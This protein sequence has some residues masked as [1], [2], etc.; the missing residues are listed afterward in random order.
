MVYRK[1]A[2][3]RPLTVVL[4]LILPALTLPAL[5]VSFNGRNSAVWDTQA[6]AA[7]C[8]YTNESEGSAAAQTL[9][10]RSLFPWLKEVEY[11]EVQSGPNRAYWENPFL[12]KNWNDAFLQLQNGVWEVHIGGNV[13]RSPDR[14]ALWGTSLANKPVRIW[15]E[16][17]MPQLKQQILAALYLR[18][19]PSEWKIVPDIQMIST[20]PA[21]QLPHVVLLSAEKYN[22]VSSLLTA[23]RPA[24]PRFPRLYRTDN[25]D[26]PFTVAADVRHFESALMALSSRELT[27]VEI[28]KWLERIKSTVKDGWLTVS[29]SPAALLKTGEVSSALLLPSSTEKVSA[30]WK[31]IPLPPEFSSF[32]CSAV[33][34]VP[35]GL[36]EEDE[37][38]ARLMLDEFP[39]YEENFVRKNAQRQIK[40]E[41]QRFIEAYE[42]IGRLA[43]SGQMPVKEA[44]RL[45]ADY[46]N[47]TETPND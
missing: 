43:I 3:S 6:L 22:A 41:T 7:F 31:E 11:L 36:S 2:F 24:A 16:S 23:W 37:E 27:A 21:D 38:Q 32:S 14:I 28:E 5:D 46:M 25:K 19:I 15:S 20:A 9:A 1:H 26:T 44:A 8:R 42:R 17:D 47:K 35:K 18:D 13:F 10:L 33:A 12:T 40:D 39:S 30:Q 34:A 4:L 29:S 45:I